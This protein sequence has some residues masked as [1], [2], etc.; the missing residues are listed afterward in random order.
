MA[1][2]IDI[3][4]L[5]KKKEEKKI[6][7]L[8]QKLA[9]L[10]TELDLKEEYEMYMAEDTKDYVYGMPYVFTMF[11]PQQTSGVKSLSDITDVLTTLTITLDGMGHSKW[12][13][14][15]SDVVGEM[16][17]SGTFNVKEK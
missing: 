1:E 12:A 7:A 6:E 9:D 5:I 17:L 11:P 2:V 15:I 10:I 14:Q 8:S 4:E 13:N 3:T 16:F